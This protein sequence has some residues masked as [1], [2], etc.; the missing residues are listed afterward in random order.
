M[1]KGVIHINQ[2]RIKSDRVS[3]DR[4][5]VITHKGKAG[6]VYSKKVNLCDPL[7]GEV[8]VSV[9]YEPAHPLSCGA[10]AWIEYNELVLNPQFEEAE[11]FSG[12]EI[13]PF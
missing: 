1:S 11:S 8:L 9:R 7:T 3:G 6:N 12:D 5:C 13:E 4:S 10:R 2:H